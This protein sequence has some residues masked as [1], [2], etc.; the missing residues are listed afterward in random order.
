MRK[1]YENVQK[2][3]EQFNKCAIYENKYENLI[4][5]LFIWTT[6]KRLYNL[7]IETDAVCCYRLLEQ[8]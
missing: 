5:F 3:C 1:S 4:M 2:E 6:A 7:L 8:K